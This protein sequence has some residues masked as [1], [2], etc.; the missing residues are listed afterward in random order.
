MAFVHFQ[1]TVDRQVDRTPFAGRSCRA[2]SVRRVL[3]AH[4]ALCR[5]RIIF[6][7]YSPSPLPPVAPVPGALRPVEGLKQVGQGLLR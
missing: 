1:S 4:A 2:H 7:R 6:T 5:S 3:K